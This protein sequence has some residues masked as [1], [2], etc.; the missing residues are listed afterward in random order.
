MSSL[1]ALFGNSENKP[2]DSDKL[3]SLYWNRAEL[4]KEFA[5]MRNEQFKLKDQVREA[6]GATAR[7]QQ[8]LGHLEDLLID[9]Q[10]VYNVMVYY[11]LR[12]LAA[13]CEKKLARFAEQLKQQREQK[14]H[15]NVLHH[16]KMERTRELR[17]VEKQLLDQ[18]EKVK[19]EELEFQSVRDR[20]TAMSGIVRFFRRRS[21]R[22]TLNSLADQ[23][24]V[25]Q[26]EE[27][28]LN[29]ALVGIKNRKPPDH[30][31]LDATTKRSIN[32]MCLSF[33]Q[34]LYADFADEELAV[35]A[36]EASEKS[37]GAT[38]YGNREECDQL[39]ERIVT[40]LEFM[41]EASDFAA[42]LQER[43]KLIGEKA[44]YHDDAAVVPAADSVKTLY[45]FSEDGS[46]AESEANLLGENYWGLANVLSR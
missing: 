31:G 1:A 29:Q 4:K 24:E 17:N 18:R 25:L 10:W 41:D 46:V 23:I 37:V 35:L 2:Q 11:Q 6:E 5:S 16:W 8:I 13:R 19:Q 14:Q 12:G 34:Q 38:N 42:V 45:R 32:L 3:V 44:Q 39:M 36:K 22:S 27:A 40:R 43:A 7:L 21:V 33:A 15:S 30:A 20:Y 26:K 9:P 28:A